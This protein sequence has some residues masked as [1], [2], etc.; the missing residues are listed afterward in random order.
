MYSFL[1]SFETGICAPLG[2]SSRWLVIP[3]WSSSTQNVNSNS[4]GSL[5]LIHKSDLWYSFFY[6]HLLELN[7]LIQNRKEKRAVKCNIVILLPLNILTLETKTVFPV[8]SIFEMCFF[9]IW[10]L[11]QIKKLLNLSRW[12]V[13]WIVIM[14]SAVMW[15]QSLNTQHFS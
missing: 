4:V 10:I 9:A 7:D 6:N 2:L 13:C 11:L 8:D 15:N 1:L 14:L 5:S 3:N 12:M